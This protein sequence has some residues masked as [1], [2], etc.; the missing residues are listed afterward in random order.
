M[1]EVARQ[2][3]LAGNFLQELAIRQWHAPEK[4]VARHQMC[5]L[6]FFPCHLRPQTFHAQSSLLAFSTE[7]AFIGAIRGPNGPR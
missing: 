6:G 1:R 5:A 4:K 3:N 2:I 7:S